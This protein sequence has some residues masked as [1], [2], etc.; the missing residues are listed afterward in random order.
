MTS[1]PPPGPPPAPPAPPAPPPGDLSLRES[2]EIQGN[3]LAGFNK[4]HQKFL[5]LQ[6]ADQA[7][8]RAWLGELVPRLATTRQVATFNQQFSQARRHRGGDDPEN[9]KALW[10]NLGL[11]AGGLLKLS[12]HLQDDLQNPAFA[13]APFREGPAKRERAAALRDEGPSDP[14][15]WVFGALNQQPI[16]AILTIAADDPEDLRMELDRQWRLAGQHRVVVVF[17]QRGETLPGNRRGHE[18][19]GFKDGISQPGVR[20]FDFPDPDDPDQVQGHPGSDLLAAGEFVVGH[21]R[22]D[23]TIRHYPAWMTDGSFQ[24]FRRLAQDVPGWWAQVIAQHQAVLAAD[25]SDPLTVDQLAAKLVGRWRSGTPLAHAPDRDN[26]SARNQNDDNDFEFVP[27]D[28]E[29]FKTPR[30]AHIRKMYPRD[31]TFR[32]NERHR[33]LRRGIPFGLHFDPALGRGHGVDAERGLCFNAFMSSIEDQFEFL[34]Q[35]WA[36]N[37]NFREAGDGPD[38]VIGTDPAPVTLRRQG[39][40]DRRLDFRRFVQTTGALYAFAPSLTTLTRLARGTL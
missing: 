24:V 40:P 19:F 8:G 36:N 14:S 1:Q 12:P 6:F 7:S 28:P 37:P 21:R 5:F 29:G 30:F 10:R 11:T 34:Q 15:R 38:P 9:L 32:E 25:P 26:R 16:D 27:D 17:E 33:I 2:D 3:I 13:L 20:G 22:E 4:D 35:H 18:H 31:D 39:R 23:G